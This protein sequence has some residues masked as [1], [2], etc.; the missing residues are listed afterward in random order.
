[1]E[2]QVLFNA[3]VSLVFILTGWLIR[4]MYDAITVLKKDLREIERE[5]HMKY[6]S[7]DDYRDDMKEIKDMLNAIFN[8]LENKADK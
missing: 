7:K 6:I 5:V 4:T 8:K 2:Y 1:M 3:A